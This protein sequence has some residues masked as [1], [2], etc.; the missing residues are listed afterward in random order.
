MHANGAL[1]PA[2]RSFW[3]SS[4]L[5]FVVEKCWPKYVSF[6]HWQVFWLTGGILVVPRWSIPLRVVLFN[7]AVYISIEGIDGINNK[8][9]IFLIS[10]N[11]SCVWKVLYGPLFRGKVDLT[12]MMSSQCRLLN[13][14]P[15]FFYFLSNFH[16]FCGLPA[17]LATCIK[18]KICH[19]FSSCR[20]LVHSSVC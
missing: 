17:Q 4:F 13:I 5:H 15:V 7:I 3:Y 14:L 9:L 2:R 6:G 8:Q 19:H 20:A 10:C 11:E 18:I 1:G 16:Q 12:V